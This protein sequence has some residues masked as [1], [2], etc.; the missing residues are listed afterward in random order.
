[1]ARV[2]R[3]RNLGSWT[4]KRLN[5]GEGGQLLNNFIVFLRKGLI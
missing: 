5:G 3:R 2:R 4:K 1:M